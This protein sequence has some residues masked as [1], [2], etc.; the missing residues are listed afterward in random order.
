[1]ANGLLTKYK[2]PKIVG[3]QKSRRSRKHPACYHFL[4][5]GRGC[6]DF[7]VSEREDGEQSV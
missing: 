7:Q 5:V 4:L 2:W 1:M 6:N 3:D